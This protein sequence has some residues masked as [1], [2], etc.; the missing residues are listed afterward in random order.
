M[1]AK[2]KGTI[3]TIDETSLVLDVNGLGFLVNC[4]SRTLT[5]IGMPGDYVD[6]NVETQVR[7][8]AITLYGFS[9][10]NEKRWFQILIN[11]QGVGA[12]AA[13]AILNVMTPDQI[14]LAIASEDKASITRADG[15]GPKLASRIITELKDKAGKMQTINISSGN[16]GAGKQQDAQSQVKT[17]ANDSVVNDA[18]SALINL[19]YSRSDAYQ[20]IHNVL[21]TAKAN[22]DSIDPPLERIIRD[23]LKELS[24]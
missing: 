22:D 17:T 15:V 21:K 5:K 3:D 9:D 11:V 4:N 12:K 1:Y 8:D 2:L 16:T 14:M 19:G 10:I 23:A 24:A 18:V 7:E 13:L 20:A 6:L